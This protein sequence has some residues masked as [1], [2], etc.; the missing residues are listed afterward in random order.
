MEIRK[1]G[2]IY[3]RVYFLGLPCFLFSIRRPIPTPEERGWE[4]AKQER[5]RA[6]QLAQRLGDLG[7][8]PDDLG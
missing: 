5:Q 3:F 2:R 8:D 7:I 6:E 4:Q 1:R